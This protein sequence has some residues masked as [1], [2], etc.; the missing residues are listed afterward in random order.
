MWDY[1]MFL[2]IVL[3]VFVGLITLAHFIYFGG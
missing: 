1:L 2:G 3:G